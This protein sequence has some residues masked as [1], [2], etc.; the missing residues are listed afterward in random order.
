MG[1]MC[2]IWVIRGKQP[3]MQ[4]AQVNWSYSATFFVISVPIQYLRVGIGNNI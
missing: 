4:P 3:D 1:T 2:Y